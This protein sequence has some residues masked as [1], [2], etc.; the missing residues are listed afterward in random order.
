MKFVLYTVCISPHQLPLMRLLIEAL[1]PEECRYIYTEELEKGRKDLGWAEENAS[2]LVYEKDEPEKCR[3]WLNDCDVLISGIRDFDLFE[4]RVS[5]GKRTI[6]SSERWFKPVLWKGFEIPGALKLLH[7]GYLRMALRFRRLLRSKSSDSFS[8]YP[9]SMN[10]ARDAAFL[11]SGSRKVEFERIPGGK[12]TGKMTAAWQEKLRLWAYFVQASSIDYNIQKK[13]R[14]NEKAMIVSG[15]RILRLLWVG[16]MLALKN[17]DCIIEALRKALQKNEK[18]SLTLVGDGPEKERLKALADGLPVEFKPFVPINEIRSIMQSHDMYIFASN[19]FD[20][21]GAVV[22]E[23]IEEGMTVVASRESGSGATI[24]PES[25]VFDCKESSA[26]SKLILSYTEL[27]VIS[28]EIW[29]A[30]AAADH[31]LESVLK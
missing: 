1:S 26:L 27:P 23:A 13:R 24:L 6:Y 11:C 20:G 25:C 29:S 2:W 30:K 31:L 12:V 10:A 14:A 9:I 16:R 22:N 5:R 21:W 8:Y 4:S 3:E 18:I 7:P 28:P 17:V 15:E 19:S